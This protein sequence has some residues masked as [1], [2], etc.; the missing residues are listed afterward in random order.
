MTNVVLEYQRILSTNSS[1]YCV[2]VIHWS[3]QMFD[4]LY[5]NNKNYNMNDIEI[6]ETTR[7]ELEMESG[8]VKAKKLQMN[9][10]RK[11]KIIFTSL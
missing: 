1:L 4:N 11:S 8:H 2:F 9:L 10:T 7:T 5:A 3:Q 6:F